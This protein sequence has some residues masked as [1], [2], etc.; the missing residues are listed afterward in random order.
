MLGAPWV[1]LLL[2]IIVVGDLGG[3]VAVPAVSS[4]GRA[5][6]PAPYACLPRYHISL[7]S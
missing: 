3:R 2:P 5:I 6:A 4:D 1:V 7:Y